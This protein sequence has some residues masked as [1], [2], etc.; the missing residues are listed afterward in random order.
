MAIATL[1]LL[2]QF[3]LQYFEVGT[4]LHSTWESMHARESVD[5][6]IWHLLGPTGLT[7][8]AGRSDWSGLYSPS[9]IRFF[10]KSP[11]VILLVKGYV[12]PGL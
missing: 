5:S 8:R 4:V 7:G 3:E 9:R 12:F 1:G 2:Q 10:V 6:Q 11:H